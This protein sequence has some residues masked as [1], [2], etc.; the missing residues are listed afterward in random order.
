MKTD[1]EM[2]GDEENTI[3]KQEDLKMKEDKTG[4]IGGMKK[5]V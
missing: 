5:M 2:D 4:Y 3:K 1:K